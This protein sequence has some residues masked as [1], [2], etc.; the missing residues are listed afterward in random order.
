[1]ISAINA[2]GFVR[3]THDLAPT[4][5]VV[6]PGAMP[7]ERDLVTCAAAMS[8]P[9]QLGPSNG[10]GEMNWHRRSRSEPTK[11]Q[12]S[13]LPTRS[14]R[15]CLV[16]SGDASGLLGLAHGRGRRFLKAAAPSRQGI[17]YAIHGRLCDCIE[18]RTPRCK[19][20]HELV[21]KVTVGSLS[22]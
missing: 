19:P 7:R 22:Q 21:V 1:M 17:G 2:Q 6:Q 20:Q 5:E 18:H 10:T 3:P 9:H 8:G 15:N 11:W 16:A 13:R 14:R 4:S 12:C